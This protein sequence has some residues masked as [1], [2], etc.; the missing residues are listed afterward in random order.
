MRPEDVL[1]DLFDAQLSAVGLWPLPATIDA[2]HEGSGSQVD[3][4]DIQLEVTVRGVTPALLRRVPLTWLSWGDWD[5]V[6][7][8]SAGDRV[9]VAFVG[10]DV[11][12]W[13]EGVDSA[14][15]TTAPST[16][17]AVILG[18]LARQSSIATGVGNGITLRKHDNS[19]SLT[20][21]DQ[22]LHATG[23]LDVTGSI[24]ATGDITA[25][26]LG[27]PTTSVS[28]LTHTHSGV[29]TGSG[30]SGPPTPGS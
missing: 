23:D 26:T 4:A 6:M 18:K 13:S 22:G 29:T 14:A 15:E 30:T 3:S 24:D 19:V 10:R 7:K 8:P 9:L 25:G 28:V 27:G 1:L 12:L 2:F 21:D 20:L 16:V 11:Q 17:S 5:I